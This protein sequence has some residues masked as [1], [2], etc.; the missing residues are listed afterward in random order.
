MQKAEESDCS[1]SDREAENFMKKRALTKAATRKIS[2]TDLKDLKK[3]KIKL[4]K[5]KKP[6]PP[7]QPRNI[8]EYRV[9]SVATIP[10]RKGEWAKRGETLLLNP[11]PHRP[12]RG[13]CEASPL[14]NA[15]SNWC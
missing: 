3:G 7:A 2:T 1:V 15:L 5:D 12:T 8:V 6:P 14:R 4:K 9:S 10:L 13:L 11:W